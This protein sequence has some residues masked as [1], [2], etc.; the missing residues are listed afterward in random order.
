MEQEGLG[1]LVVS[2]NKLLLY[3]LSTYEIIKMFC[4]VYGSLE[5]YF[6]IQV[7]QIFF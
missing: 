6:E 2:Y 4:V 7:P 3:R 5:K 1:A